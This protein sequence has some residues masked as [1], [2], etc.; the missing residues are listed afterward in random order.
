MLHLHHT[1]CL[2][3]PGCRCRWAGQWACSLETFEGARQYY[4]L[5]GQ[6]PLPPPSHSIHHRGCNHRW[7]LSRAPSRGPD[8]PSTNQSLKRVESL[9]WAAALQ[10]ASKRVDPP[11][12]LLHLQVDRLVDTQSDVWYFK[13]AKWAQPSISHLR[14]LMRRVVT[15]PEVRGQPS[16]G[17]RRR[18]AAGGGGWCLCSQHN[19]AEHLHPAP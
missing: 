13:G 8:P 15:L 14:R 9:R 18:G 10:L 7:K 4:P 1:S 11:P 16:W 5:V 3:T 2:P 12:W 19:N 17:S 6:T